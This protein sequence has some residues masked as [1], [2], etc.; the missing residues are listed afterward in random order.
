MPSPEVATALILPLRRLGEKESS[1]PLGGGRMGRGRSGKRVRLPKDRASGV[2][3][4][5]A[6]AMNSSRPQPA[7]T[8]P[9]QANPH[10]Q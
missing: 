10:A 4:P 3:V 1:V 7:N 9:A 8:E 6:W 5:T 2:G